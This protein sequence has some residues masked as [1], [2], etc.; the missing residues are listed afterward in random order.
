MDVHQKHE[1]LKHYV[2]NGFRYPLPP[3][4]R[5]VMGFVYFS[6]PVIGGWHI[7]QWA[8]S[9]SH[10]SIGERGEKLPQKQIQGVGNKVMVDTETGQQVQKVGAGGWGGG[11][12]LAVSDE[13]VQERNQKLLK[14][15]LKQQRKLLRKKE[16]EENEKAAAASSGP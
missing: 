3:W 7:M 10:A 5:A 2:H 4:G 11:V 9:K 13:N 8:I 6:L 16:R 15:Y 14:T 1:R 12:H